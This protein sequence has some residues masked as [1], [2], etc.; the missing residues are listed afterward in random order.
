MKNMIQTVHLN[1]SFGSQQVLS[2]I[3]LCIR[4][5]EVTAVMG[6]NG[7]GKSTLMKS[8]LGL[9]IPDS[10]KIIIDGNNILRNHE[11]RKLIGYM[12][13]IANYPEN[14]SVRELIDMISDIRKVSI[15]PV[16]LLRLFNIENAVHKKLKELSGGMRQKVNAVLALMFDSPI[17]IF[18][19]PTVGLDP[20]SRI[21]FKNIL[22][23]EKEKGKTILLITHHINEIEELSDRIIFML[24]GKVYF[25]GTVT[26]LKTEQGQDNLEKAA[27]SVLERSKEYINN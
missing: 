9:V 25:N 3:S 10:G 7:S 6:P 2:N 12:P 13:Q 14:I 27:A 24:D 26:E 23:A 20:V 11:Y 15:Y 1:K 21:T 5:G 17:L 16:E 19:E 4:P 8:V 18:D 22:L